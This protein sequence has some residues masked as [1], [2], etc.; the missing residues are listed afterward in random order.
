LTSNRFCPT[1]VGMI[2]C[3]S[4]KWKSLRSEA[5]KYDLDKTTG[6]FRRWGQTPDQDPQWSPYGP[7]ILDL[8][9]SSG[10][11][12]RGNCPFCYKCNGGDQ[13]TYNMTLDEFKNILDKMPKVLN[14]IAFGIM[15]VGTNPHFFDMM[16]YAAEKGVKPNYTCHG[17]DVTDE[18]ARIS[19]E[20]CG[21]VAVS[22]VNKEKTYDAV[23]KFTESLR[24]PLPLWE[25]M[26]E[27]LKLP[28]QRQ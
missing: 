3:E 16:R 18:A 11:D 19:A 13:P 7:E 23:R 20:I 12:C 27:T 17:L 14:Q 21:A 5:Y 22:L 6:F 24:T 26:N 10:G 28:R 15:D 1:L 25:G 9:I 4:K 2:I 8:E